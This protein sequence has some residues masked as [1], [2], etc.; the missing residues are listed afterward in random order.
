M[1]T[2]SELIVHANTTIDTFTSPD[3]LLGS[4]DRFDA[5]QNV[6]KHA[7]KILLEKFSDSG[8]MDLS[9]LVSELNK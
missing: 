4:N 9:S 1:I 2:A 6:S 5:V 7:T 3:P 8:I